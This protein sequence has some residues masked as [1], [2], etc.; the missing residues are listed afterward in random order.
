MCLSVWLD[1]R[2]IHSLVCVHRLHDWTHFV[3][4]RRH[5]QLHGKQGTAS[6]QSV[7]LSV[8]AFISPPQG[9]SVAEWL[10][11]WTQAQ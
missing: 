6:S 5:R 4:R 9:G 3:R 11:Y 2:H 7:N 8:N 1:T 10:A